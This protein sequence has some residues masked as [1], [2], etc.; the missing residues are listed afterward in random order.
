MT[1]ER[2]TRAGSPERVHHAG[3]GK[4]AAQR[5][6]RMSAQRKQGA[7]LRVFRGEDLELAGS[8]ASPRPR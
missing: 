7:V 8:W 3:D 1:D 6:R 5:Q 4:P 2:S